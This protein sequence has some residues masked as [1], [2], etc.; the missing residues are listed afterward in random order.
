MSGDGL[1]AMPLMLGRFWLSGSPSG[2]ELVLRKIR[3]PQ[4]WSEGTERLKGYA[5]RPCRI[6]VK[7]RTSPM[8]VVP[9]PLRNK[10]LFYWTA[11]TILLLGCA[12]AFAQDNQNYPQDNQNNPQDN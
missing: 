10:L 3:P 7:E 9:P 12:A 1:S 4:R 2:E 6:P 11:L 5:N 8:D